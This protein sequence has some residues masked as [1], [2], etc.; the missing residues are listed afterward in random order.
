MRRGIART[1][2]K[3]FGGT[4]APIAQ[5]ANAH[6]ALH[7]D[8][9]KRGGQTNIKRINCIARH[10]RHHLVALDAQMSK[11]KCKTEVRTN[12]GL[13]LNETQEQIS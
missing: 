8:L 11:D 1:K 3:K 10:Q 13:L 2:P 5:K 6:D 9:T 12:R 7:S 4:P